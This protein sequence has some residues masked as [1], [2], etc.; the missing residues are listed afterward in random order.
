M[1]Q[2]TDNN[3]AMAVIDFGRLQLSNHPT[4]T[5]VIRPEFMTKESEDDGK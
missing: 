1:E 2:F 3:S 5:E 4:K